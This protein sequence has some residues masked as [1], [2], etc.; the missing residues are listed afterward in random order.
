MSTLLG[1]FIQRCN[2][3]KY[4]GN[5]AHVQSLLVGIQDVASVVHLKGDKS[6]VKNKKGS[7]KSLLTF[8]FCSES[9]YEC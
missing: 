6:S 2:N 8:C 9:V 7:L 1:A 4:W 5:G 3:H